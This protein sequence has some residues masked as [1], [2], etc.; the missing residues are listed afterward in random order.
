VRRFYAQ[1]VERVS[2]TRSGAERVLACRAVAAWSQAI[3]WGLTG[4]VAA[5]LVLAI[6]LR[7][8]PP[9]HGASWL[10]TLLVGVLGALGGGALATVLGFGGL[11]ALDVRSIVT[12]ALG[13]LLAL[14]GQ[15]AVRAARSRVKSA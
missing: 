9:W 8:L 5:A 3:W 6:L 12:G 10:L 4:W 13:A 1:A 15:A 14:L 2:T 11:A 7:L